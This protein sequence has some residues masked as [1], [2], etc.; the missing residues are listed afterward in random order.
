MVCFF[1]FYLVKPTQ[2][3]VEPKLKTP[4]KIIFLGVFLRTFYDFLQR[5]RD[6]NPRYVAIY[7]LSKRAPSATRP[8]LYFEFANNSFFFQLPKLIAQFYDISPRIAVSKAILK[9]LFALFPLT[10]AGE[11]LVFCPKRNIN[12]V[13]AAS[14]VMSLPETTPISFKAELVAY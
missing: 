1:I 7:T 8:P 10:M 13:I 11:V 14:V 9:S 6:S 2:L 12:L 4:K 5:G 3:R